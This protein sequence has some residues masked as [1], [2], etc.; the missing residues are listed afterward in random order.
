MDVKSK[1]W[2]NYQYTVL[3][4]L[5]KS[6]KLFNL[7]VFYRLAASGQL[8]KDSHGRTTMVRPFWRG[9]SIDK[10]NLGVL[11]KTFEYP[12]LNRQ[13]LQWYIDRAAL[14]RTALFYKDCWNDY[15]CETSVAIGPR[16]ND[17]A[18]GDHAT[19]AGVWLDNGSERFKVS[20]GKM[21]QLWCT[22]RSSQFYSR[23]DCNIF[24]FE[25]HQINFPTC[26]LHLIHVK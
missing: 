11:M 22:N 14:G 15:D 12:Q 9:L 24:I 5:S 8:W 17:R 10:A 16:T 1:I 21:M 13:K 23:G 3:V 2:R 18:E 19:K 6:V 26:I 7:I 25:I 20:K 4:M